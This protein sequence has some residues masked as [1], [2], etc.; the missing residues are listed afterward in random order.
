MWLGGSIQSDPAP[1]TKPAP[2]GHST[3]RTRGGMAEQS[4]HEQKYSLTKRDVPQWQASWLV[5][6]AMALASVRDL[7]QW[8][9][10]WLVD[11]VMALASIRES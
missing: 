1:H 2:S 9:A 6:V 4:S 8:R 3:Q 10:S 11:V 5:D 7:P